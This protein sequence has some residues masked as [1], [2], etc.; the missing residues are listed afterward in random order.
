MALDQEGTIPGSV[1]GLHKG[2]VQQL[3]KG[4]VQDVRDP[5]NM[6]SISTNQRAHVNPTI[7]ND[8]WRRSN[9]YSDGFMPSFPPES[10]LKDWELEYSHGTVVPNKVICVFQIIGFNDNVLQNF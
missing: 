9:L 8:W 3:L 5:F 4:L 1:L 6:K 2:Q 7:E 10:I